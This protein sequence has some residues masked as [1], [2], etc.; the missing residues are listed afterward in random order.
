MLALIP[1]FDRMI[2]ETETSSASA[3]V[4]HSEGLFRRFAPQGIR[5]AFSMLRN[6]A[7]AEEAAQEA[8]CKLWAANPDWQKEDCEVWEK[9]F[10]SL[11]FTTIRNHCIDLIRK[12]SKR[13]TTT[14][15]V[16]A[17]PA[18][19]P[20]TAVAE[21]EAE[22]ARLVDQLPEKWAEAL[23][24]KVNGELSYSEIA[25]VMDVTHAQVRTWIYRARRNLETEL[26]KS[27][28]KA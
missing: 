23:K 3:D 25:E 28:V 6:R 12:K 1:L 5:Y 21:L 2:N 8:L 19:K 7:D 10:P 26:K 15:D 14:L 27:G 16:T 18:A 9:K 20:K 4:L 11:F 17:E 24:L 22:V 13:K